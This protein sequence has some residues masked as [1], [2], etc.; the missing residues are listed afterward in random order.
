MRELRPPLVAGVCLIVLGGLWLLRNLGLIGSVPIGPL[1]LIAVGTV[2]V[3]AALRAQP[4]SA[5]AGATPADT[6]VAVPLDGATRAR[7]LLD[8]G[9]GTLTVS[10]QGRPGI[11]LE[12]RAQGAAAP[13]IRRDGDVLE[14]R[15]RPLS[16]AEPGGWLSRAEALTWQLA[17]SPDIPLEVEL[18]TGASRVHADLSAAAVERLTVRTGASDVDLVLPGRG[19][20]ATSISA[21]AAE[22]RVH[23]PQGVAAAVRNRT[24]LASFRI[25][26][27]RFPRSGDVYRSP[28]Y[29]QAS[30]RADIDVE[31]GVAAFEVR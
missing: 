31:G 19:R 1:L 2:I 24:A 15:L 4:T 10:G 3:V 8:H 23:V 21:G 14:V 25:D 13:I 18:R 12:G 22:I 17:L 26:E 16:G 28:D 30:A 7:V 9:A 11:L 27:A 5:S 6:P 20:S 29:E